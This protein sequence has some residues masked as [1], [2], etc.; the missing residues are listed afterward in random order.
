[1]ANFISWSDVEATNDYKSSDDSK[2]TAIKSRWEKEFGGDQQAQSA[3]AIPQE[4][5]PQQQPKPYVEWEDVAST[6]QYRGA[7]LIDKARIKAKH[8]EEF[9]GESGFVSGTG[10]ALARGMAEVGVQAGNYLEFNKDYLAS[11]KSQKTRDE[12]KLGFIEKT[13]RAVSDFSEKA[14]GMIPKPDQGE[15]EGKRWLF[16]GVESLPPSVAYTAPAMVGA[17]GGRVLGAGLG[18]V[19]GPGAVATSLA[20]GVLG[21]S[22]AQAA[23]SRVMYGSVFQQTMEELDKAQ[24]QGLMNDGVTQEAKMRAAHE[25][26]QAEWQGEAPSSIIE[27]LIFSKIP[28]GQTLRAILK[29]GVKQFGKNVAMSAPAELG[30]E[31]WTSYRQTAA[32]NELMKDEFK[33]DPGEAAVDVLGP[34]LVMTTLMSGLGLGF[35]RARSTPLVKALESADAD[36]VE[37]AKAVGEAAQ[38]VESQHGKAAAETFRLAAADD[39]ANKRAVNLGMELTAQTPPAVAPPGA[40]ATSAT[41]IG[42]PVISPPVTGDPSLDP[43]PP[44]DADMTGSGG[45]VPP[46]PPAPPSPPAGP[47]TKAAAGAGLAPSPVLSAVPSQVGGE[48]E[49]SPPAIAKVPGATVSNAVKAGGQEPAQ[50]A[51]LPAVPPGIDPNTGEIIDPV[52]ANIS[53][54]GKNT[55]EKKPPVI[56]ESIDNIGKADAA[57]IAEIEETFE[58]R[59]AKH[60]EFEPYRGELL[61][62]VQARKAALTPLPNAER[63][64]V[65]SNPESVADAQVFN[66][67]PSEAQKEAG[68]YQ[69]A[70]VKLDG[71][72]IS[73]ENPAGSVRS[74]KDAT[75]REWQTELKADYGYFKGTKGKDKDHIDV[76]IKPGYQGGGKDV[77]VVNQYK[78]DG[79]FDEH[80]TVL[81][82][83]SEEEAMAI[84]NSNY[85]DGWSGGKEVTRL[86]VDQFKM[87]SRGAGPSKGA[88][89]GRRSVKFGGVQDAESADRDG[90]VSGEAAT[91]GVR[92]DVQQP[93]GG[94]DA[95]V[96]SKRTDDNGTSQNG[97]GPSEKTAGSAAP[98]TGAD[99]TDKRPWLTKSK[100][101]AT[102]ELVG[103]RSSALNTTTNGN[104]TATPEKSPKNEKKDGD[105]ALNT[106]TTQDEANTKK[107]PW[108]MTKWEYMDNY[109]PGNWMGK[110]GQTYS[111]A[112]SA[113]PKNLSGDTRAQQLQEE[114]ILARKRSVEQAIKRGE[115]ISASVLADY[116]D[117]EA[118]VWS[119]NNPVAPSASSVGSS[120]G[121]DAAVSAPQGA[122]SPAPKLLAPP[123]TT[124]TT[125]GWQKSPL[126]ARVL[127]KQLGIDVTDKDGKPMRGE[128]IIAAVRNHYANQVKAPVIEGMWSG[129]PDTEKDRK[130]IKAAQ[131]ERT[132]AAMVWLQLNE[133]ANA[134]AEIQ[135][136]DGYISVALSELGEWLAE[137]KKQADR[138]NDKIMSAAIDYLLVDG[139][140]ALAKP[141]FD[142][143][144]KS[145]LAKVK[146]EGVDRAIRRAAAQ[147][148]ESL[149]E[150]NLSGTAAD[151][152]REGWNHAIA[153]KSRSSLRMGDEI[154]AGYDAARAFL[155][156][157]QG[158]NLAQKSQK[159]KLEGTGVDLVRAMDKKR[160]AIDATES[161]EGIVKKLMAATNRADLFKGIASDDATPGA[162][163]L[164]SMIR[165]EFY[166]FGDWLH[167]RDQLLGRVN[168]EYSSGMSNEDKIKAYLDL[169]TYRY[170]RDAEESASLR[171]ETKEERV[172]NLKQAAEDYTA[173]ILDLTSKVKGDTVKDLAISFTDAIVVPDPARGGKG[174]RW[175]EPA[176]SADKHFV[177][178][179]ATL[180]VSPSN[181]ARNY[182]VRT[183]ISGEIDRTPNTVM[184][185]LRLENDESLKRKSGQALLPPKL[186]RVTRS[187]LTDHRR[188]RDITPDEFK[189][190]FGF[191]DVGFG[192]Y[193]QAQE[194]QDH[195]NYSYDS[196]MDLA[197]LLT[198]PPRA[199]A[200]ANR[201]YFSI[202]NL[203]SG[204]ASAHYNRAHPHPKLGTVPVIN[205]T[206][207]RGD[208]T[209]S[210]EWAHALDITTPEF[211]EAFKIIRRALKYTIDWA[212]IERSVNNMLKG[213]SYWGNNRDTKTKQ[214]R[215]DNAL[216]VYPYHSGK[217]TKT[218]F[219]KDALALDGVKNETSKPYWS[220][221][222]EILARSFE[223]WA[224]DTLA[225]RG[226]K[227][228]Y[229]V[230]PDWVGD[231]KVTGD[232]ARGTPYPG[233]DERKLFNKFYSAMVEALEFNQKT[234][235]LTINLQRFTEKAPDL[236]TENKKK[237]EDLSAQFPQMAD[238]IEQ[239]IMAE[240]REERATEEMIR[241][242]KVGDIVEPRENAEAFSK[243]I[244]VTFP[245]TVVGADADNSRWRK[246]SVVDNSGNEVK[247]EARYL[248]I[249]TAAEDVA[250]AADLADM[251]AETTATGGGPLS[252]AELENIFNEAL[253]EVQESTQEK[254]DEPP[255]GA[256]IAADLK[257]G[258][259]TREDIQ[260]I[261]SM[262]EAGNIIMVGDKD[263][264]IPTIH[265]W[266]SGKTTHHGFGAFTTETDEYRADWDGGGSMQ[267]TVGG[268]SYTAVGVRRGTIPFYNKEAILAHL[269]GLLEGRKGD[270]ERKKDT[271]SKIKQDFDALMAGNE[272]GGLQLH[273]V[274]RPQALGGPS[275]F[276]KSGSNSNNYPSPR[277]AWTKEEAAGGALSDLGYSP[278]EIAPLI[279]GSRQEK[280]D[281][282]VNSWAAAKAD[283]KILLSG[284]ETQGYS[285]ES[286]SRSNRQGG[287]TWIFRSG[288][289]RNWPADGTV[290]DETDAAIRVLREI[291]YDEGDIDHAVWT[292]VEGPAKLQPPFTPPPQP[293]AKPPPSLD[294]EQ[295]KTVKKLAAEA[296]KLGVEGL[297]EALTGLV[298]LFGGG[299][300]TLMSFP[301][302]FDESTYQQAKPHFSAALK[303]FQAAGQSLKDLF[304]YLIKNFG[305]GI[306]PYAMRFAKDE[307]LTVDLGEKTSASKKVAEF[308]ADRLDRGITTSWQELF[309]KADEAWGGTQAGNVYTSRDAY[310]AMEMGVNLWLRNNKDFTTNQGQEGA[311]SMARGLTT[312]INKLLPTQTKRTQE[313]E[314]FQ[315]FS[316]PPAL[317]YVANWVAKVGPR[318]VMME[319]SAGTGDL[320]IWSEKAGATL[321]LNELSSRRAGLLREL[322][323]NASILTEDGLQLNNVLPPNVQASVVVMN[324]PFSAT[325][326]RTATND[327]MNGAK[328]LEQALKRLAPGGR[329]VAIVGEG[330]GASR[331]AFLKWWAE[332]KGKYNVRANVSINGAEYAKYGTTF[333]NQLLVIDNTGRTTGEP[334]TVHVD[335]VAELPQILEGIRNERQEATQ[336]APPKRPGKEDSQ[337]GKDSNI[338]GPDGNINP[339]AL[340]TGGRGQGGDSTNDGGGNRVP[341]EIPGS[342]RG[343]AGSGSTRSGGSSGSGG[344]SRGKRGDSGGTSGG[345]E[346]GGRGGETSGGDE[347]GDGT[348]PG[349]VSITDSQTER[350]GELTDAIFEPY[351][352]QR[353]SI[354]GAKEHPGPLVQSAAM[355]SVEPPAPTY[356]PNLPKEVVEKGLLSLPQ[357]EAVVY[358]GQAHSELLPDGRRR[359]FFIGDN[360]G[361]GKGREISGIILDNIRQGRKKAVWVSKSAGL[362]DDARRDFSGIGGDPK[363]IFSAPNSPSAPFAQKSG[364]LFI[365]Y[366]TL[367]TPEKQK[368]TGKS[369]SRLDQ[370]LE[371][372]G[373]DYDGVIAFDEAH[374]MGNAVPIKGARG[375]S[376]PS[377]TALTG[378][379]LQNQ[380][381]NARVVYVSATGA[382]EVRNLSYSTRLG[383]WGENTPFSDVVSFVNNIV[384]GGVA[385][386]EMVARDM[387][388]LGSY[389]ARSLSFD[390]V[391]YRT[392]RHNLSALNVAK[393]DELAKMWQI[394]LKDV[395]KAL[396]DTGGKETSA[397]RNAMTA[398]WG[399]QQRFF[400]Q[401]LTAMQTPA[402]IEDAKKQLADGKSVVVQLT[403]HYSGQAEREVAQAREEGRELEDLDL[404]PR[405]ML[406]QFL[407]NAFP[408][409]QYEEKTDDAGNVYMWPVRDSNGNPVHN[410]DAVAARDRLL[411]TL[412]Q[413]AIPGNPIDTI[414]EELGKD[415]VA[416]I[417]GRKKRYLTIRDGK[418][419]YKVVEEKRGTSANKKESAEFQGG[420]RRVLIFSGAGATGF[421]FHADKTADNQQQRIHY[422][423]QPGWRADSAVQ[424]FGRTHRTNQASA[425]EYVLVSTDVQAQKRFVSS[426][427]RRLDQLGALTKGQRETSGGLFNASDNLESK[428]GTAAL[429]A[430]FTNMAN[431]Y[432]SMSFDEVTEEM[433]LSNLKDG[434]GQFLPN[435]I[436]EMTKFL[437]RLLSLT[438]D[439]QN[440]VFGTFTQYLDEI[441]N[442]AIQQGTY[443][444]GLQTIR[445]QN[446]EKTRD[447]VVFTDERTGAAT[448]FVEVK[449]SNPVRFR[450][451]DAAQKWARSRGAKFQGWFS[452]P[453]T[454]IFGLVDLGE[455]L[456]KDG[457]PIRRGEV[458]GIVDGSV[459]HID[460]LY[461]IL[462]QAAKRGGTYRKIDDI[463]EVSR[464]W[465]E[466]I[467][468]APKISTYKDNMLVG[469]LMPI[470]DRI[471]GSP[472]ILRMQTDSGEVLLGRPMSGNDLQETMKNLGV[473]SDFSGMSGEDFL[474]RIRSGETAVLSNGWQIKKRYVSGENR[475][476]VI[477][478]S[479]RDF[480]DSEIAILKNKG[481]FHEVISWKDRMFI[482][483]GESAGSIFES[484]TKASPVVEMEGGARPPAESQGGIDPA[485]GQS[486]DAMLSTSTPVSTPAQISAE[487][488]SRLGKSA[489]AA[490]YR[491]GMVEEI[492]QEEAA[493][494]AGKKIAGQQVFHSK[495]GTIQGIATGTGKVYL[496]RGGI[497]A[498]RAWS[499]LLHEL[500]THSGKLLQGNAGFR[501]LL[502]TIERR[503]DEKS[504]TGE[505]IREA[506][507]KVPANTKPEHV[508]EEIMAYLVENHPDVSI[509]RRVIA[510]IK[511]AL[512]KLGVNPDILSAAD[513]RALADMA[514]RYNARK[515]Q[516]GLA[517][518]D[519]AEGVGDVMR[520]VRAAAK[521]FYSKF[522]D[523]TD[524]QFTGM[525]AQSVEPFL[526]K[527][528]VKKAEIEAL[529]LREWLATMKPTD[530]VTRDQLADFVRANTVEFEDV[531]LGENGVDAKIDAA[532]EERINRELDGFGYRAEYDEYSEGFTFT[533]ID[534]GD[535]VDFSDMPQ[536]AQDFITSLGDNHTHFA[537]LTE[538]GAD[539][540]SYRE[541]FVTAPGRL[542]HGIWS[543]GKENF[544]RWRDGHSQYD[545]IKNP[546]VRIRFNTVTADGRALMRIEEMQGPSDADQSNMPRHLRDNIYQIGVKR[547]IAY[548]K[549]NGFDGITF[550]TKEGRSAGETQADR[551]SLEKD[552]EE[553]YFNK[554]GF[555]KKG[556]Q[557][558]VTVTLKGN[559]EPTI[560]KYMEMPEIEATLGKKVA[561]K[562]SEGSERGELSGLDLK[563]GGEGLKRLYDT[564]L[565]LM[566]EA[567]GKEKMVDAQVDTTT[568]LNAPREY[569]G[570][571]LSVQELQTIARRSSATIEQQINSLIERIKNGDSF[572]EAAKETLSL[573]S[574]EAIGGE[575]VQGK[576]VAT[577]PMLPIT[578]RTP[579]SF[580]MFSI[581][582]A[583]SALRENFQH[584]TTAAFK[585]WFG[586]SRITSNGQPHILYHGTNDTRFL[587]DKEYPWVFDTER[588]TRPDS[589]PFA[590]LGIFLGNDTIAMAHSG[591]N[592][593]AVHP[594][595][596]RVENPLVI[597]SEELARK[598]TD[599]ASA[600]AFRKRA[601]ELNGHDGIIIKDRGQV[602]VFSANQVKSAR[603][604]SGAFSRED[605]DIRF[606]IGG[607]ID[608]AKTMAKLEKNRAAKQEKKGSITAAKKTK[609]DSGFIHRL[610][611]TPEYY[612]EKFPAAWRVLQA[613]L[614]R[615]DLRFQ[616]QQAI[617]GEFAKEMQAL[618]K[619][620]LAAYNEANEYLVYID[621]NGVGFSMKENSD[622]TWKVV[623]GF[624]KKDSGPYTTESEA[625]KAMISSEGKYLKEQGFSPAA[626]QAVKRSREVTNEGFNVMAA[627]MRRIIMEAKENGL[628]DPFIGDGKFDETGRYGIYAAGRK[629]P[630]ALFATEK[631]ANEGLE[632]A[633]EMIAYTVI[634][635]KGGEHPFMTEM[636]AKAW[637][638]KHGGTVKGKKFFQNLVVRQRTDAELRP[639]TVKQALA[640]MGDLRGTYFPRIRQNGDFILIAKKDGEN[641]IR[642]HFDILGAGVSEDDKEA[643]KNDKELGFAGKAWNLATPMGREADRLAKLGY[644]V[645]FKRDESPSEDM[646]AA[647]NL[648]TSIDAMLQQAMKSANPNDDAN[649]Q[650]A[651]TIN[652]LL[653]MQIAD[654]FKARGY[655]SSRMKR[656]GGDQVWEGYETDMTKALAAYAT[657]VA[658]G[659]AKRD[660]ARAMILAFTGKDYTWQDYKQEVDKPDFAEWQ[661]IVEKRRIDPG[662]QKNLYGDVRN[663][664]ID[665]LR[666]D[667]RTDRV[668]G[669]LRGL[670]SLKFL[671]FRVSSAAVN[672]TNMVQG[673]PATMAAHLG[674]SIH[675]AMGYVTA[676][677]VDYGKYRSGKG[678]IPDADRMIF[679]KISERGWDE[680][681]FNYEAAKELRGKGGEAWNWIMTKGMFMFGAVEKANRAM[682]I[683]AAYK[684][685]YQQA[686]KAGTSTD[687]DVLLDQ[688]HEVSNRAHGTYGDETLP[689]WTRGE[690]A[691]YLRLP[692]TFMKFT[693]NY[694]LNMWDI[695]INKKDYA[696]A[697]HLLLA[698][699]VL[700][701]A[702]ATIATPA[703]VALASFI[704]V[705]GDDPE[706]E[707][708]AWMEDVFGSDRLGRHGL[709]GL[710][711]INIKGSLQVNSPMPTKLSELAGAPGAIFADL[712]KGAKHFAMGEI[713]K[714]V[715]SVAP[716]ALGS[717]V[718][719]LRES[720]EGVTT[721]TYGTVFYGNEPLK[722]DSTDSVLRFL[723]F[724]PAETSGIREKQFKERNVAQN[725]QEEKREINAVIK[726]HVLEGKGVTPEDMKVIMKF[727]E[728]AIGTGRPDIRPITPESIR[729][730]LRMS[731]KPSKLERSRAVA[732]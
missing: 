696:A 265:D 691:R 8:E 252:D 169:K 706:E 125:E 160:A 212:A 694:L 663:F 63:H 591:G 331:P 732:E 32:Q 155:K 687:I 480:F 358:A 194:D 180:I 625:I 254:P 202:G 631:E 624:T 633:A 722:A 47:V 682:S 323:P 23:T 58:S 179:V 598:V 398:F 195:L 146:Q 22:I 218:K 556:D 420:K 101:R 313:Q 24:A 372:L 219:F 87:W 86:P 124:P 251:P 314:Q 549:E 196:F 642:K 492:S 64:A 330:M 85:E 636:R 374:A 18:A 115:T 326:G 217:S 537:Q 97:D 362:I 389:I 458:V 395:N 553:V 416:E 184:L 630:V 712:A 669:T 176:W 131:S 385:A 30:G 293:P 404:T 472:R 378:V 275:W 95:G 697:A 154:T 585:R 659:T 502:K 579:G 721:G 608:A 303:K 70:H 501:Q 121:N 670:A 201:L 620:N 327:T 29:P 426:I 264:G 651:Q 603:D 357:L 10:K 349:E 59:L 207:T 191:A 81:G 9:G 156:T 435:N 51:S 467:D 410:A 705:G 230:S 31:A 393:Y 462:H 524:N 6:P 653:T 552:V 672:A 334:V 229:L 714:G 584:P 296:A 538:P 48:G 599:P 616:N 56:Q 654:L 561:K 183:T 431:G 717:A 559:S 308:I 239:E 134:M 299:P 412:S 647:T 271:R 259:W 644:D 199:L 666:N 526:L 588:P 272:A 312:V 258:S 380:A 652:V 238:V 77:Y 320:A 14:Q 456:D 637:A 315:Q 726:R 284:A 401:V 341:G 307:E 345:D 530:K 509:A 510:M 37:R 668:I 123:A 386:M 45:I 572:A 469:V 49:I 597:T 563:V 589:S 292:S 364:I 60:P 135:D 566:F 679:E 587:Q 346:P 582:G 436:P 220:N 172:A 535:D 403:N 186:D 222:E 471:V 332:I 547:A 15:S 609:P 397:K 119:K 540:G 527:Q 189:K 703:L 487:I 170:T 437:N 129:H 474:S 407:R 562:I 525:K 388:A 231:G 41:E 280:A 664:I 130:Q 166:T 548:A 363:L 475:I 274:S 285:I 370:L 399:A 82:A 273:H 590:G 290:W 12:S 187:G 157:P 106:S 708:Y 98:V 337:D 632:R 27:A 465:D 288:G 688:A 661:A 366:D 287:E 419:G 577:A 496:V 542:E 725:Y 690:T 62:A 373:P 365:T 531:V 319:P 162:Q 302:G 414:I 182:L 2:K 488:E 511:A 461:T 253:N 611:S 731:M 649:L 99:G 257:A 286:A 249:V 724:N 377:Q 425:P 565:P 246:V 206:N 729:L 19:T 192:D 564:D 660:T 16:E 544:L 214:V 93:D 13:G 453:R 118:K 541:M 575:M 338:P 610:L 448:R 518:Q 140:V 728:R 512:V 641:P 139:E 555:E 167:R 39:V 635:S 504:E 68:N 627:D 505:K 277:T 50:G 449:V 361:V 225:E 116:P 446:I 523:V 304:V 190:T 65:V 351:K 551:Y 153:G 607:P 66:A 685:A 53:E 429:H 1:M 165:G 612:F 422:V 536:E 709:A 532:A 477:K 421:S 136:K 727:N 506:I 500:G 42:A 460:N 328:H 317:A 148:E 235:E 281:P 451:F 557:I 594:V 132:N 454:K 650:Q 17:V 701:G 545:N 150:K 508:T 348:S 163:K 21:S 352:P 107:K 203:G 204:K 240:K 256:D 26:A 109:S 79:T 447:E 356:T 550:A 680:A 569:V 367:K 415:N 151:N 83:T 396:D 316:T 161:T 468:K 103:G 432:T 519:I 262:V 580:P 36:P 369:R 242:M 693:H 336:H 494:I 704:G 439:R 539:P 325:A 713:L 164:L 355:A 350:E 200:F 444:T 640:Q 702:G 464:A 411:E 533:E 54:G 423:L 486:D 185:M 34:T 128:D 133:A 282:P 279:L 232:N 677:A 498:K 384:A 662:K 481:A 514:V 111:E 113:L 573:S 656:L 576:N 470:W 689:A 673:V 294:A 44:T 75:G 390:G 38:I 493:R 245:A 120:S 387:K 112:I 188:G 433:G 613:A 546:I 142:A 618:R 695:G 667:D 629:Q 622:G 137:T 434:N 400:N 270:G 141:F 174:S 35:Q 213:T 96:D 379:A 138:S 260:E 210:H 558:W 719:A 571:E 720:S 409:Q 145:A 710:A 291:G 534:S 309:A 3:A 707:F 263:L 686:K 198:I 61:A 639:L 405:Q 443:D 297:D 216:R 578:N 91:G 671:A 144:Y 215:I 57:R 382:T 516:A 600:K 321:I 440:E 117:L 90:K 342:G 529:G 441:V 175:V 236:A 300:N 424:G 224:S 528:G 88:L 318:D 438:I 11:G 25:A 499:V 283:Y 105:S 46:A 628:P 178:G 602:V 102:A 626:I 73:V 94:T 322:F 489:T 452:G 473:G 311:A 177:G 675:K 310:D 208:G 718:R 104:E 554:N 52:L 223:A 28:A 40:P 484:I 586:K 375:K 634:D 72:D 368:G 645:R 700:A 114:A 266:P 383:L 684:A 353:L 485:D 267:R 711:G 595:Y 209:V 211:R 71:F 490:L 457:K 699:G 428:Y 615:R 221:D 614:G 171:R 335:S 515:A 33:Q 360:T 716:T 408:T 568:F 593:D 74:G 606:S 619:D 723:S 241:S 413:I 147:L 715:E 173:A 482:P 495:N 491:S 681:Q 343:G 459:R 521:A 226:G 394:V 298:K 181:V 665:V 5:A 418:G 143:A 324:P 359:G 643:I 376:K 250:K 676:A 43:P 402:M 255:P 354:P 340:D 371:W 463:E 289:S 381:R 623:N 110:S 339:D 678:I 305:A 567:W 197:E 69:K 261:R 617:L 92:Q 168:G 329:L 67:E 442:R 237:W 126:K 497:E 601:M 55:N 596:V 455:R 427:A 507:A 244:N 430:L 243:R 417:T 513:F 247:V 476:E 445:A 7:G 228:T 76:F 520:S 683:Y 20:G 648:V 4:V 100:D 483:E 517:G 269:D 450:D 84:Y 234:G 158:K 543:K 657:G 583:T 605:N 278:E 233:G 406:D 333:D 646:F 149:Q 347:R 227:N 392:L 466:A 658:A 479:G 604:N 159:K 193:V 592:P 574:A 503:K 295:Q 122:T 80:K 692:Y 391:Q 344:K 621:Q 478:G 674:I 655:L 560:K 698:P 108:E 570:P 276:Y 89:L 306:K 127:A 638:T 522:A 248:R 730:M 581:K 268:R 301:A 205:V 152:F 78:E